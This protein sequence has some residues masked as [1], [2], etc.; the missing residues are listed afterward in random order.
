L[1]L[2]HHVDLVRGST[3]SRASRDP[4]RRVWR[5]DRREQRRLELVG[6]ECG[7][8]LE[9]LVAT[10]EQRRRLGQMFERLVGSDC[11]VAGDR[12]R[13]Q[14]SATHPA[15]TSPIDG[16]H[17]SFRLCTPRGDTCGARGVPARVF[18]PVRQQC[19]GYLANLVP[20][21]GRVTP[22]EAGLRVTCP[23]PAPSAEAIRVGYGGGS[24]DRLGPTRVEPRI[25]EPT[26]K[27]P[28]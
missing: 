20:N 6:D 5:R 17:D 9:L 21:S 7:V 24:Q 13:A 26:L 27:G 14:A 23:L 2:R 18:A 25:V 28:R 12:H 19:L 4:G 15:R 1:P 11:G 16:G 3:S 22:C 8:I 10:R